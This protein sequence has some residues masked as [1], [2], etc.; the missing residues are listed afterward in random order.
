MSLWINRFYIYL[1]FAFGISL[2]IC[3]Q[4]VIRKQV[5]GIIFYRKVLR[6]YI[7]MESLECRFSKVFRKAKRN[8]QS[9]LCLV[10]R[11][12]FL[13]PEEFILSF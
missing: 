3:F 13:M 8:F 7:Y 2:W 10:F 6:Y 4:I 12:F 1:G 11:H 5:S 9:L